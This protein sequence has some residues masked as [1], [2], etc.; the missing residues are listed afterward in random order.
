[1][2]QLNKVVECGRFMLFLH[3]IF[4]DGVLG[5]PE[6]LEKPGA[7]FRTTPKSTLARRT[8][9]PSVSVMHF[10]VFLCATLDGQPP[11]V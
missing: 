3:L 5:I 7:T 8:W 6:S 9:D 2:S 1:M 11:M 4:C 10:A